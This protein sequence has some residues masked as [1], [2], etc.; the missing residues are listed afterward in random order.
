MV[1]TRS[2]SRKAQSKKRLYRARVKSSQC[3]G[4]SWS[5]CRKRN[6]C[7]TT[8]RGSRRSYCRKSRNSH[9]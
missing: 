3:R 2:A 4:K 9:V 5:T 6:G 1:T 7:K 8:R